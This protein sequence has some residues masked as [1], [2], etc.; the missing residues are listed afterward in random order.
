[1]TKEEKVIYDKEYYKRNKERI[2][3]RNRQYYLAYRDTIIEKSKQYVIN[4][5]E[6]VDL[7]Q[8]QYALSHKKELDLYEAKRAADPKRI[9]YQ[10]KKAKAYRIANRDKVDAYMKEYSITHKHEISMLHKQYNIENRS[11]IKDKV[12]TK[13]YNIT[14]EQYN[15]MLVSQGGGCAICGNTQDKF[16]RALPIDHD[17]ITGKIRGILCPNCNLVLGN[18]REDIEILYKIIEYL[19]KYKK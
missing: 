3:E 7:F 12:I 19:I 1:M 11:R 8:K 10:R 16:K 18:A 9:E 6:K 5:K 15:N 4:N 17:H 14:L 2:A 13:K